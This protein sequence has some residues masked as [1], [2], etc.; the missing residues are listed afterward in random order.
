VFLPIS[1]IF[2]ALCLLFF[3]LPKATAYAFGGL[4]AWLAVGAWR[5]AFR[6]RADR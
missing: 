2:V 6:R 3:A 4:S 5:E 1:A